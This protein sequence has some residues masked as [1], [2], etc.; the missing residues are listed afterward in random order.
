MRLVAEHAITVSRQTPVVWSRHDAGVITQREAAYMMSPAPPGSFLREPHRNGPSYSPTSRGR[1]ALQ[2]LVR[3]S[4]RSRHDAIIREAIG[5][6]VGP[7]W[8][9]SDFV[10]A[11][12]PGLLLRYSPSPPSHPGGR[13]WR[14]MTGARSDEDPLGRRAGRD[15]C[16]T[17]VRRAPVATCTRHNVVSQTTQALPPTSPGPITATSASIASRI[18]C[19]P[20]GSIR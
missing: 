10:L 1:P 3:W 6:R 18:C 12:S 17:D 19:T 4:R 2:R 11:P 7:W 5:A 15:D 13:T 14:K 20:N 8:D 16:R 9:Q